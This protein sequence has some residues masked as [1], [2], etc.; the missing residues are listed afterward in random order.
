MFYPDTDTRLLLVRE[1]QD[2]L[3]QAYGRSIATDTEMEPTLSRRSRLA[4]RSLLGRLA[5]GS[6]E[7]A[8]LPE[9]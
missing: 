9:S 5:A 4:W 6:S 3:R 8:E 2:A 1:H 7:R